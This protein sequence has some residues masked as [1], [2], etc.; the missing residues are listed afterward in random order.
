LLPE[1]ELTAQSLARILRRFAG[2]RRE[3]LA[4][5][6]RARALAAPDA[7]DKVV[8]ACL[9]GTRPTMNRREGGS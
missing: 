2:D 6:N 1:E 9:S 3:L 5:A 7:C 8:R 4:M